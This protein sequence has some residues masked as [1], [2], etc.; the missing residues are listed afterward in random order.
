MEI[1]STDFNQSSL[2]EQSLIELL[3]IDSDQFEVLKVHEWTVSLSKSSLLL[4][5]QSIQLNWHYS[6]EVV[7]IFIFFELLALQAQIQR[8]SDQF[9]LSSSNNSSFE[10][11]FCGSSRDS[12]CDAS[13][14]LSSRA[15]LSL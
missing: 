7:E 12:F 4:K 1:F 6:I 5:C 13:S 15:S 8:Y 10:E 9:L 14:S 3:S 2:S 11:S